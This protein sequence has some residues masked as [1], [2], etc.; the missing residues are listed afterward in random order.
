MKYIY[1]L[2]VLAFFM[3]N[4]CKSDKTP[5]ISLSQSIE[6]LEDSIFTENGGIVPNQEENARKLTT[7]YEEYAASG[8]PDSVAVA[9]LF[10]A[11]GLAENANKSY[12]KAVQILHEIYT[13]YPNSPRAADAEFYE[14]FMYGN[15][16][17][18]YDKAKELYEAFLAKYPDSEMATSIK[19]ELAS[20]GKTPEQQ[21]EEIM[22][23]NA[24]QE[25]K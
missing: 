24:Q 11:A 19:A 9:S 16:L 4:A 22:K 18:D 13:K 15:V 21:L 20:F 12:A 25:S 3:L 5:E 6:S 7:V 17:K 14:A 8:V 23:K 2:L 1:S 10:K